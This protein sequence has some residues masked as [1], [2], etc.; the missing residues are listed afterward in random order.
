MPA[1]KTFLFCVNRLWLLIYSYSRAFIGINAGS[2]SATSI[3]MI[4]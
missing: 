4:T 3:S 1:F 2:G